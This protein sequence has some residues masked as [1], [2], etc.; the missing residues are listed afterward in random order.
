MT[1]DP[2]EKAGK[3]TTPGTRRGAPSAPPRTRLNAGTS[4][5]IRTPSPVD[6]SYTHPDLINTARE[7]RSFLESRLLLVPE[8]APATT[9]TLSAALFQIAATKIP[10]EAAQ[11]IRSVAWL[12]DEMEEDAVAATARDAVNTQLSYMNDELRTLTEHF[13]TTLSEEV[14]KQAA[15]MAASSKVLEDKINLPTPY[16]DA[17]IGQGKAPEGADPRVIA[18]A[19]I[20]ARQFIID[21]PVDSAMQRCSQAEMLKRFNEAMVNATGEGEAEKRRIR[22]VEKLAN[23]GFLGEFLH[24]EGAKWFSQQKHTDAFITALGDEAAGAQLKK[25]NHPVIAYYV[26]LNLNTDSQEHL[27]EVM[28]VNNIQMGDLTSMRWVKPPARRAP[29]QTCGHL[30]LLFSDPDAANWAK[31]TGLVICNK[32]VSVSKYKKEPI[33]C[34]KC[35]GWNHIAAECVSKED[36]SHAPTATSPTADP[37]MRT[38]TPAGQGTVRPSSGNAGSTTRNTQRTTYR[39]TPQQ[40]PGHGRQGLPRKT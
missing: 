22:T 27:K 11:A 6:P 37:A 3:K 26:P 2:T 17:V 19:G 20:R 28:E 16:R 38:T 18:R 5:S 13:R 1:K 7:G 15:A 8:G 30:I 34:L 36:I 33:R 32:R 24:D 29:T 31:T 40:K 39:T 35:Q 25:R 21:F 12:L 9:S 10:R 23:K 14:E 4:S